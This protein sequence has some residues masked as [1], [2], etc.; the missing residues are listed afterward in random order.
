MER[1]LPKG[2]LN[3]DLF[4]EAAQVQREAREEG[5]RGLAELCRRLGRDLD[6][7]LDQQ[8]ARDW[9]RLIWKAEDALINAWRDFWAREGVDLMRGTTEEMTFQDW[10]MLGGVYEPYAGSEGEGWFVSG[11][12]RAVM[13]DALTRAIERIANER[14]HL[15][16][17][18][19][20]AVIYQEVRTSLDRAYTSL[21]DRLWGQLDP[22]V[23][24][25]VETYW[26]DERFQRGIKALLLNNLNAH[27]RLLL[28][29]VLTVKSHMEEEGAEAND[30]SLWRRVAEKLGRPVSHA[31]RLK[32]EYYRLMKRL[33]RWIPLLV[34]YYTRDAGSFDPVQVVEALLRGTELL[35]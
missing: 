34:Q 1:D 4:P 9:Y 15:A 11:E 25:A 30:K 29:T 2:L 19:A 32:Q 14:R 33:N 13:T 24:T 27:D 35:S 22:D 23:Q 17:E 20:E 21:M 28:D 6:K 26:R 8:T 5:I 10:L 12:W 7:P 31:D 3:A 18:E 16:D